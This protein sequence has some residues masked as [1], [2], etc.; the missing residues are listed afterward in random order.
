MM[1]I[2]PFDNGD[3]SRISPFG[4]PLGSV[5]TLFKGA[6]CIHIN[7]VCFIIIMNKLIICQY[8]RIV[9]HILESYWYSLTAAFWLN[10]TSTVNGRMFTQ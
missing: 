3:V 2:S 7:C 8:N 1:I 10:I 5:G 9:L 6:S 4:Q